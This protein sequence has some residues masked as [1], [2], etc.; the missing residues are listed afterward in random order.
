MLRKHVRDQRKFRELKQHSK[1]QIMN[2]RAQHTEAESHALKNILHR[3]AIVTVVKAFF[4]PPY[5]CGFQS[6]Q[7]ANATTATSRNATS[8]N[9]TNQSAEQKCSRTQQEENS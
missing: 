9:A 1:Q 2:M 6:E 5:A 8:T 3:P 4:L 7:E